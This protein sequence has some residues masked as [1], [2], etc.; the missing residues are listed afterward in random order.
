MRIPGKHL[1]AQY[2]AVTKHVFLKSGTQRLCRLALAMG[3]ALVGNRV[4]RSEEQQCGV[5]GLRDRGREAR[6]LYSLEPAMKLREVSPLSE[7]AESR[8]GY[9]LWGLSQLCLGDG[10]GWR[11]KMP[12]PRWG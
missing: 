12:R 7:W 8:L 11:P 3:L 10:G 1:L 9:Y 6:L 2:W 5:T 4:K